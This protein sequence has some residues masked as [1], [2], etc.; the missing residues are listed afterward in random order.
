M[1]PATRAALAQ[2]LSVVRSAVLDHDTSVVRAAASDDEP[3][4]DAWPPR[5]VWDAAFTEHIVPASEQVWQQAW[6][7]HLAAA[8][9]VVVDDAEYLQAHLADVAT[10]LTGATWPDEVY[11]RVRAAITA[12][13]AEGDTPKQV[14]ARVADVLDLDAWDSRAEVIARTELHAALCTAAYQAG[15]AQQQVTGERLW[16]QW[17]ATKD[18][19][20]RDAH[21]RVN[22]AVV[23]ADEHFTVDGEAL[24]YPHDPKGSPSNTIQCR[25]ALNWLDETEIDDARAQYAKYLAELDSD[26]GP[27]VAGETLST[28]ATAAR[29]AAADG[30]A[31]LSIEKVYVFDDNDDSGGDEETEGGLTTHGSWAGPLL[32]LDHLTGD[33]S[34]FPR[35]VGVP[36]QFRSTNHPWLSYQRASAPAHHGKVAIG[37]PEHLWVADASLDGKQVPH[38]WGAG[39][40]DLDDPDASEFVRK[41]A[42]GYAGTVS[43]DLDSAKSELRWYDDDG[44]QVDEPDDDEFWDWLDGID[45]GKNP[46]EY[47]FDWRFAGVTGV[48][49]PAFHTGWI[50]V[51][52]KEPAEHAVNALWSLDMDSIG[53]LLASAAAPA[54]AVTAQLGSQTWC[55]QVADV[56]A[57]NPDPAW[58]SNP[59]LTGPTKVTVTSEGRVFGHIARWDTLHEVWKI[60]PPRCPYGGSYPKFHR[61]PVV[62]A[63]GTV[64]LTGPLASNGHADDAEE[65]TLA[66][67]QAHYDDPN[68][69]LADVVAGEDEFGIWVSG[70]LRPGVSPVQVLFAYRYSFSGDWRDQALIAACSCAVPAYQLAHDETV[71]AMVAS[72]GPGR[73]RLIRPKMRTRR[74]VD[75]SLAVLTASGIVGPDTRRRVTQTRTLT[76]AP[77]DGATLYREFQAAARADQR[78]REAGRRVLGTRVTAAA[79]RVRRGEPR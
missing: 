38:L 52:D 70:S 74:H 24:L 43:A 17:L 47:V 55:E 12:A 19:R 79:T 35:M 16:K 58:F 11:E 61:H 76:A 59:Q 54:T 25:C 51:S 60:P 29:P 45:I 15:T 9:V 36:E 1:S 39:T 49:D 23:A 6:Q 10:R 77:L 22:G 63:D 14:Q 42:A 18:T 40:F 56:A 71:V 34:L 48:Q 41:L 3:D 37:R 73:P 46:V 65:V 13:V 75:G 67:A 7:E 21:L 62:A 31:R 69:V 64:V 68:H 20:T 4:L 5:S 50:R 57:Y 33:S 66:A 27:D 30:D 72:A 2:Y 26:G 32:A 8:E 78:G 28:A 44:K 53:P